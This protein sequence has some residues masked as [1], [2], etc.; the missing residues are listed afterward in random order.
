MAFMC[1]SKYGD[2]TLDAYSRTGRT[3]VINACLSICRLR[4][5]KPLKRTPTRAYALPMI[6]LMRVSYFK[7]QSISTPKSVTFCAISIRQPS[8]VF[9]IWLL[10]LQRCKTKH[11][12]AL[13]VSCQSVYHR[14]RQ[15]CNE[16]ALAEVLTVLNNSILSR[17]QRVDE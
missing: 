11:F 1:F 17:L 15:N 4:E 10:V 14:C 13:I 16:D 5:A 6:L 2:Q 7:L 12:L 8:K 9:C 3:Y